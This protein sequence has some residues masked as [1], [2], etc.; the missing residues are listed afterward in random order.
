MIDGGMAG[1]DY[2]HFVDSA[3]RVLV[4]Q[5]RLC[6]AAVVTDTNSC[7]LCSGIVTNNANGEASSFGVVSRGI[8][9]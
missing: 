1:D 6:D 4:E 2:D 8:D 3:E 5:I 7:S 9:E